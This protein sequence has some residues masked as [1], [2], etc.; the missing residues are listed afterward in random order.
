MSLAL[1]V[2][3]VKDVLPFSVQLVMKLFSVPRR[4]VGHLEEQLSLFAQ[5]ALGLDV[6]LNEI[7]L[8]RF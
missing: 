6:P 2:L 5:L 8:K 4:L 7:G 1:F 3:H